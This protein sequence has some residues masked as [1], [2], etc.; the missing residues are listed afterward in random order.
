MLSTL[1]EARKAG[2][3][4]IL[5]DNFVGK[6]IADE[7]YLF[8]MTLQEELYDIQGRLVYAQEANTNTAEMTPIE[9]LLY[10]QLM[11]GKMCPA[12]N[13]KRILAGEDITL[14]D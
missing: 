13:M 1:A 11:C 6:R 8:R 9:A 7:E 3:D 2:C 4:Y 12:R 14:N 5:M 10:D